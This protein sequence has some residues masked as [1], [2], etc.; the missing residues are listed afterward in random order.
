MLVIRC[1]LDIIHIAVFYH[2]D[3]VY[4]ITN[5]YL[6]NHESKQ[7]ELT[8]ISPTPTKGV[9]VEVNTELDWTKKVMIATGGWQR[10]RSAMVHKVYLH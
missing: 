6:N 8:E 5:M 4:R 10:I 9:K 1:R 7:N 2:D 3:V